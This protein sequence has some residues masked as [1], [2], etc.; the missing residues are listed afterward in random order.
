MFDL[1]IQRN[2]VTST[3]VKRLKCKIKRNMINESEI[4]SPFGSICSQVTILGHACTHGAS[5][6]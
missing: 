5:A 2:Y 3:E 4:P 1:M 6:H